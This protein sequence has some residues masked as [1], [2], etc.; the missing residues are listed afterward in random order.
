MTV[1]I[2][3]LTVDFPTPGGDSLRVLDGVDITLRD[4]ELL[5]IIGP[6][7]CGKTTL[8]NAVAG[9]LVPTSGRLDRGGAK[10]AMVFQRATLLPWQSVL[11]NTLFGLA[12][13]GAVTPE[14]RARA[15]DL[16]D[17]MRLSPHLH[18][19][20]HQLS[21]GMQ[22]R[23]NLARALLIKPDVLLLDEPLS[24]LDIVTRRRIQDDFLARWH[25]DGFSAILVSHSLEDVAYVSSRVVVLSDKPTR[26]LEEL[27]VDVKRPRDQGVDN[28]LAMLEGVTFEVPS[29]VPDMLPDDLVAEFD[30]DLAVR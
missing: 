16:L 17:V 21:E 30:S 2:E 9:L 29:S 4:G 27:E 7:G 6:S 28:R 3:Q 26:V 5:S 24:A 25:E 11:D 8:L 12:C 1:R 13:R 14:A 22:Q 10:T 15:L 23:V 18:D 20:P 19:L